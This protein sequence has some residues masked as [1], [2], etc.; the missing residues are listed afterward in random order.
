MN[1]GVTMIADNVGMSFENIL[2]FL[3]V[4]GSLIIMAKDFRLGI[5]NMFVLTGGL[6]MWFYTAGWSY[7][8]AEYTMFISLVLLAFTLYSTTKSVEGG[9]I[10]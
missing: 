1:I 6:F 4:V 7:A 5:I 2:V 10:I 8:T 9:A 3:V